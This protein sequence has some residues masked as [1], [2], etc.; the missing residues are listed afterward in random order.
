MSKRDYRG[1]ITEPDLQGRGADD[2]D[3]WCNSTPPNKYIAGGRLR[4]AEDAKSVRMRGGEHLVTN[5]ALAEATEHIV[6]F[7]IVDCDNLD[8]AIDIAP[9]HPMARFGRVEVRALWPFGS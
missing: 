2:T 9:R 3:E 5:G 8:E 6:G 7:D 1:R 4:P